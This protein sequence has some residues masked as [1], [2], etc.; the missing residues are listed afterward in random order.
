MYTEY[1]I[2]NHAR[3]LD[4]FGG[5]RRHLHQH[6]NNVHATSANSQISSFFTTFHKKALNDKQKPS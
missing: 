2:Q 4:F 3:N 6:L 5:G 1:R